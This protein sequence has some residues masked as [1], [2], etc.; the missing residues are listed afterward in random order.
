MAASWADNMQQNGTDTIKIPTYKSTSNL[1]QY[2]DTAAATSA[3]STMYLLQK[4]QTAATL[5][6]NLQ[7]QK[8]ASASFRQRGM[9]Q[10]DI[11]CYRNAAC[12]QQPQQGC[13]HQAT[14]ITTML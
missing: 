7:K 3:G 5:P 6:W 13:C 4:P 10:P 9:Q 14:A 8:H 1:L 2:Y 11:A 12:W